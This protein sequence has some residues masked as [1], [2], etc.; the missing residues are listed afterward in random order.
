MVAR[1]AS[2]G[3][4]TLQSLEA[5]CTR[6]TGMAVLTVEQSCMNEW[7]MIT[8]SNDNYCRRAVIA[9]SALKCFLLTHEWYQY[10]AFTDVEYHY[11]RSYHPDWQSGLLDVFVMLRVARRA[12]PG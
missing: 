8:A 11:M 12:S 10:P 3:R 4:C 9:T 2:P 6:F 7:C 5:S 1:R